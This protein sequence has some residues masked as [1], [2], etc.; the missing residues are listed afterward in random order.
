MCHDLERIRRFVLFGGGVASSI[1]HSIQSDF[2]K[3]AIG[4]VSWLAFCF[5]P[6]PCH[7]LVE[8]C[9]HCVEGSILNMIVFMV[10]SMKMFRL[11]ATCSFVPEH[12]GGLSKRVGVAIQSP[13]IPVDFL[14]YDLR[15]LGVIQIEEN[16]F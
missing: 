6:T 2:A 12:I 10:Y 3:S 9:R 11:E 5:L 14:L 16:W 13:M 7:C 4:E 1:Q 8:S 15:V